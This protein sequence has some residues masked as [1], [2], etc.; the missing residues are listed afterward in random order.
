[1]W[2]VPTGAV[3]N[4]T[5]NGTSIS[6]T[7][8]SPF[9]SG[10]V[11]VKS[12]TAC[13][14]S[15]AKSLTVYSTPLTPTSITGPLTGVCSGSTQTY[16]CTAS[17][18]GATGY[19][20]TVPAGA[21]ILTGGTSNSITVQFP[22][23][24][25]SGAVSVKAYNTCGESLA[26]S[27]T[28]SSVIA[29]PGIIAG[30]SSNLCSGG[31]FTYTIAAVTGATGYSWNVPAGW[32]ITANSGTSITVSIPTTGFTS[33]SISVAA[34]NACGFG[35]A[36]SLTLSALPAT[37]SAITGS[38]SVCPSA[39]G[40]VYSTPAVSGVSYTW[41]VPTG[42]TI[43]AGQG[44][45]S[46]E[47]TW[48]TVAGSVTVK[49]KNA[50]GTNN[51]AKTLAVGL[52]SCRLGEELAEEPNIEEAV[53]STDLRVYPNPTA[54]NATV[55]FGTEIG[56]K[57]TINVLN[58]LGQVVYSKT[59]SSTTGEN[60]HAIDISE[61]SSGLYFINLMEDSGMRSLRLVKK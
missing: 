8:P 34:Q 60:T 48:G 17:T 28:V 38:N 37:P 26:K 21:T 35:T 22:T 6:I 3:I 16:T 11:S 19:N 15:A 49:A 53:T 4:G 2:T 61:L 59:A 12:A 57:Y 13:Y 45:S 55:V 46:I 25:V 43:T 31:S 18:T 10:V 23:P 24:F 7:L 41:T 30:T 40:L 5:S 33:A 50:C 29:Q 1:M 58:A 51:T 36:R 32:I 44:T 14:T 52:A 39:T 47:V 56:G 42:A 27:V 54:G 9:T 20:W